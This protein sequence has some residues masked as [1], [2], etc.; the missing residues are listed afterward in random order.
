MEKDTNNQT[1]VKTGDEN[2]VNRTSTKFTY[3]K[4]KPINLSYSGQKLLLEFLL[5]REDNLSLGLKQVLTI[6]G[7]DVAR[8]RKLYSGGDF[9]ISFVEEAN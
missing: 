5:Q 4:D 3:N 2:L 6:V 7:N 1:M 8:H 9:I